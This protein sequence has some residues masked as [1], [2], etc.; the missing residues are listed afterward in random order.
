MR[1]SL[2]MVALCVSMLNAWQRLKAYLN[3]VL[4]N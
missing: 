2:R 4:V 1:V 3:R